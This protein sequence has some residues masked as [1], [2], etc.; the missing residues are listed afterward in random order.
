MSVNYIF[1]DDSCS[2][3]LVENI[4]LGTSFG[5]SVNIEVQTILP[6]TNEVMMKNK[7]KVLQQKLNRP[8]IKIDNLS[9]FFKSLTKDLLMKNLIIS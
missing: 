2:D 3:Q 9:N 5:N 6:S 8:K 7:I 4:E 1:L